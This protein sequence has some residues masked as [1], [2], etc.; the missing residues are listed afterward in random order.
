VESL[1]RGSTRGPCRIRWQLVPHRGFGL[2]GVGEQ[3]EW[4]RGFPGNL[5]DPGSS[6]KRITTG[7]GVTGAANSGMIRRLCVW[8]RG[9]RN[10]RRSEVSPSEGNEVRREDCEG[11][12]ASHSTIEAGE[13][14]WGTQWREGDAVWW[15][16][17]GKPA[18]YAETWSRVNES[19]TNRAGSELMRRR[20]GCGKSARPDL[21]ESRGSNPPGRPGQDRLAPK[22]SERTQDQ[23]R[24]QR[25]AHEPKLVMDRVWVL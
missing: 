3:G 16:V 10:G 18:R 12:A 20:T 14:T 11:V 17:G 1:R 15:L 8:S 21:W 13:P 25:L 5:G 22:S 23:L 4:S 19:P 2:A 7:S 24:Q 9:G 6:S